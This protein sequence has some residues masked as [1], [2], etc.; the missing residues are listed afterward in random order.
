MLM[1][2]GFVNLIIGVVFF[3][4]LIG[5]FVRLGRISNNT[6][7]MV[8]TMLAWSAANNLVKF[9]PDMKC[10]ECGFKMH[11]NYDLRTKDAI[12]CGR[13]RALFSYKGELLEPRAT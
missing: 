11:L 3:L 7:Q 2:T 9:P 12:R 1:V 6:D 10:P 13:C 5:I 4:I 8:F